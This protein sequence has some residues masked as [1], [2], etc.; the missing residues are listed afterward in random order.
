LEKLGKVA[1][2]MYTP[3]FGLYFST[4]SASGAEHLKTDGTLDMRFKESQEAM[5]QQQQ[6]QVAAA[7]SKYI[8]TFL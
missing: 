6:Q 5:Q 2:T 7:P 8:S 3:L 1:K 4:D